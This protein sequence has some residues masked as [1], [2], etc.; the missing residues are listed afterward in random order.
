MVH[1]LW[2]LFY[3]HSFIFLCA[4]EPDKRFTMAFCNNLRV[5]LLMFGV[6]YTTET[7]NYLR[8]LISNLFVKIV[9]CENTINAN[10]RST[11]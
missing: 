4:I 5:M 3:F 10:H 11:A 7:A 1:I 9:P 8:H 2:V 6:N